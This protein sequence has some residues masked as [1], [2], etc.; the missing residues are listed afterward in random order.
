MMIWVW[1]KHPR[2]RVNP[3]PNPNRRPNPARRVRH[4]TMPHAP[5]GPHAM[6]PPARRVRRANPRSRQRPRLQS[7]HQHQPPLTLPLRKRQIAAHAARAA[8]A[9][10][11]RTPKLMAEKHPKPPNR[12][13]VYRSAMPLQGRGGLPIRL[14]QR[15]KRL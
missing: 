9:N 1:S 10:P 14:R 7:L 6:R 11:K 8:R 15:A 5:Q 2:W 12:S 4:A 13:A 3:N